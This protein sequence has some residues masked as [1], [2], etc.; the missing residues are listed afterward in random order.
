MKN[1]KVLIILLAAVLLVLAATYAIISR[2]SSDTAA[3]RSPQTTSGTSSEPSSV[4]PATISRSVSF[5]GSSFVP[6]TVMIAAGSALIITNDS[7]QDVEIASD[8]HPGHSANPE[9]NTGPLKPGERR[10]VPLT[11]VGDWSY[12]SHPNPEI[13]GL[14]QVR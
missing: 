4:D 2:S 1:P 12:H 3:D 14:V 10:E 11:T 8:P 9:L 5:T 13:T 6:E 7:A